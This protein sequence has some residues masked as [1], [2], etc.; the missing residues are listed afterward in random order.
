MSLFQELTGKHP[1]EVFP[2]DSET[3][4]SPFPQPEEY[5]LP[6][7]SRLDSDASRCYDLLQGTSMVEFRQENKYNQ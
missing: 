5:S 4:L 6:Y 1:G 7:Q 3:I 2:E